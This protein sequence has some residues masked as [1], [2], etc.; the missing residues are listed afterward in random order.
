MSAAVERVASV[1]SGTEKVGKINALAASRS[2]KS[3]ETRCEMLHE[4][5]ALPRRRGDPQQSGPCVLAAA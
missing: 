1:I 2:A 4:G 3:S 5:F